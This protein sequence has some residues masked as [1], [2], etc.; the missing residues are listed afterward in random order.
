M[1]CFLLSVNIKCLNNFLQRKPE[2][3]EMFRN[4]QGGGVERRTCVRWRAQRA[5]RP[6]LVQDWWPAGCR[7]ASSHPSDEQWASERLWWPWREGKPRVQFGHRQGLSHKRRRMAPAPRRLSLANPEMSV[8]VMRMPAA[9]REGA[10]PVT[11]PT[12]VIAVHNRKLN[13]C[14]PL[15]APRIYPSVA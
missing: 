13:W 7:S 15:R 11:W 6:S 8:A 4:S 2:L 5:R 3:E 14:P 9:R 1:S 10:A 12:Q